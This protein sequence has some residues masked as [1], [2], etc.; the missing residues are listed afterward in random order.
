MATLREIRRKLH[1]VKNIQKIT[2]AMEMVAASRLRRA[3]AK[4]EMSRRYY[5]KLEEI[6]HQL[7]T[8]ATDF[9]HPLINSRKV[10]KSAFVV[11]AG[12]RGLCGAYNHNVF[13]TTEKR[14]KDTETNQVELILVGRKA[15]D[16]FTGKKWKIGDKI[17]EWGGK[18]SYHQIDEFTHTIINRYL[19]GDYD[20]VWL[21]Y[22]HFIT[23]SARKVMVEKLL[24][25]DKQN[26][27]EKTTPPSYIFEPN[28]EEIFAEILPRYCTT[29]VQS[30]LNEA[31]ASELSARIFSM[32]AATKNAEEMIE[33]LTLVRNK[34]R[35][36]SITRELIEITS[37]V[38]SLK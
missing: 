4:A 36:S 35:Q 29:K 11:I 16:Y 10:K 34:I 32:R 20:E 3:Q 22:T 9:V 17:S 33:K 12:D 19:A 23:I 18:I 21:I 26:L 6:L 1:S 28:T 27:E 8:A 30:A 14:L 7:V 25:I 38:E 24:N 37:C 5:I 13:S 31:Y 2:Q 15:I